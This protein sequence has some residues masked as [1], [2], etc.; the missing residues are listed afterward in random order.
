MTYL[1]FFNLVLI[2]SIFVIF[3]CSSVPNDYK[4]LNSD[5]YVPNGYEQ[6]N[7]EHQDVY[8]STDEFR[9]ISFIRHKKFF[10]FFSEND[11]FEIYVAKT[12]NYKSI[13]VKYYY[14][15]SDWIFFDRAILVND[16]G[17]RFVQT[18]NTYKK[19]TKVLYDGHVLEYIDIALS[20]NAIDNLKEVLSGTNV[21]IKF[22]GEYS[23]EYD[24]NKTYVNALREMLDIYENIGGK[25]I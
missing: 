21:R 17:K 15:G 18:I 3:G 12:E 23:K 1:K 7:S 16:E 11:P 6:L 24:F 19:T 5:Q 14:S 2:L 22:Y 25:T 9:Q 13:R 10:H 20:N 8:I 4:Q